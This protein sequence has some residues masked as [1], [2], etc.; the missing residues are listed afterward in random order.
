MSVDGTAIEQGIIS[1]TPMEVGAGAA[2]TADI[3]GGQ[4]HAL[5]VPLGR[6]LIQIHATKD[7]GKMLTDEAEGGGLY[8]ETIDLVPDKYKTGIEFT[9][10]EGSGS[11]DIELT[12]K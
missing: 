6:V 12:S 10:T 7:T 5:A 4:Y 3:R 2:V 1:F 8:A 11:H 9:V